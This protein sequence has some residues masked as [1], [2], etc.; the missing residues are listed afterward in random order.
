MTERTPPPPPRPDPG[1][2][3]YDRPFAGIRV[4]DL[5]Q[6]LAGP[7]CAG[8]LARYGADVVKL[9]PPEG[10]W[11]R[12]LGTRYGDHTALDLAANRGK[13]SIVIDLKSP[14]GL[15]L[16]R[17]FAAGA[18][19]VIESFR[20]GVAA[21]LGLGYADL[22]RD[23][24][25]LLYLSV[26]GYG[27]T[28]PHASRPGADSVLQA[29]SGLMA[30]NRDDEGA[31]RRIGFLAVDQVTSLYGF[32][33]VSVALHARAHEPEG[34]HIDV[35]L[36]QA[37]AALIAPKLIEAGLE[38]ATP[39][40]LNVPAGSY[41]TRDGWI[42][43]TL[44]R[45]SHFPAICRV[46]GRD[47]LARDRRFATFADRAD[48]SE[49]LLP[50]IRAALALRTTAEWVDAFAAADVLANPIH[51]LVDWLGD[52][53]VRASGGYAEGRPGTAPPL[54]VI[55]TP[56]AD[57]I[58]DDDARARWPVPGGDGVALMAELGLDD[59]AIRV[60]LDAG[61]VRVPDRAPATASPPAAVP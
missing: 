39:R 16:A 24:P 10:D 61:V 50:A 33:A 44:T 35:S 45:E 23:N 30:L 55:R 4:L 36:M 26:S 59:A 42:A 9:E 37:A 18:D 56:G 32:Q 43:V 1:R 60:L 57:P 11:A 17:R 46:I 54:P 25:R 22:R 49:A 27:Q 5:S 53:H 14:A 47:D 7:N 12:T 51:S 40:L 52:D 19:V 41:R 58:P 29:F 8:L 13:R 31:P 48:H 15:D 2:P 3:S 21:R 28:G 34:R 6:G 20:P 38:G